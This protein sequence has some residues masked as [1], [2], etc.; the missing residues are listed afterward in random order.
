L[1]RFYEEYVVPYS[2]SESDEDRKAYGSFAAVI[3]VG[4]SGSAI[5]YWDDESTD[6]SKRPG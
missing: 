4:A 5:V 6:S 1:Q 3:R 2:G